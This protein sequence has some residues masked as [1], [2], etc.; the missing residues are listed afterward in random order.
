M[1]AALL[2]MPVELGHMAVQ[3]DPGQQGAH[4]ALEAQQVPVEQLAPMV[5]VAPLVAPSDIQAVVPANNPI[6]TV[7]CEVWVLVESLV[8]DAVAPIAVILEA[9]AI[10][11]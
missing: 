11:L 9:K 7:N 1:V 2:V 8:P 3:L 4:Q 10:H 5:V 6:V